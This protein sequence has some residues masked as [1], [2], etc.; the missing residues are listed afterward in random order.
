MVVFNGFG[1]KRLKLGSCTFLK[2]KVGGAWMMRAE[3]YQQLSHGAVTGQIL[4]ML[5]NHLCIIHCCI[6]YWL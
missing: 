1:K 4:Q 2:R 3:L 6:K 5:F